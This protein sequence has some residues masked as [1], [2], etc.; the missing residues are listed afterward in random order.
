MHSFF[1]LWMMPMNGYASN[2]LTNYFYIFIIECEFSLYC[3]AIH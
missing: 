1:E 2:E 3:D